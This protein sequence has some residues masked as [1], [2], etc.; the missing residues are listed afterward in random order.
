MH[1]ILSPTN[2]PFEHG[3]GREVEQYVCGGHTHTHTIDCEGGGVRVAVESVTCMRCG[4][5]RLRVHCI[6][7]VDIS[8]GWD[9]D[10]L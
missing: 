8:L 10:D 5:G 9:Q 6:G 1:T 2:P 3:P 4:E 7:M